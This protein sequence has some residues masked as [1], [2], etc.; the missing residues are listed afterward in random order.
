MIIICAMNVGIVVTY[1]T[2]VDITD[3]SKDDSHWS[4]FDIH[5][6]LTIHHYAIHGLDSV[7]STMYSYF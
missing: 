7:M 4:L 5:I 2:E 3:Q 6:H 1:G